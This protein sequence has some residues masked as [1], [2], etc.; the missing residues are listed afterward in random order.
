[1]L[2]L[3]KFDVFFQTP[4]KKKNAPP[5]L[6][7]TWQIV[8][9]FFVFFFAAENFYI[10]SNLT[11]NIDSNFL[12]HFH[13]EKYDLNSRACFDCFL[14]HVNFL[15]SAFNLKVIFIENKQLRSFLLSKFAPNWILFVCLFV[16]VCCYSLKT[17][18]LKTSLKYRRTRLLLHSVFFFCIFLSR[19]A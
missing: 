1:M 12:W 15:L 13:S 6:I 7:Q 16:A 11:E 3:Q 17:R 4:P 2:V 8:C 9:F 18:H 14:N 5:A 19:I 10:I